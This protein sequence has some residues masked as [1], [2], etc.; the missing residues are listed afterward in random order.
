LTKGFQNENQGSAS[1]GEQHKTTA[2]PQHPESVAAYAKWTAATVK[3]FSGRKI[4]WEIWNEPNI[5][6][7]QPKP[8]AQQY[9]ALAL[10]SC[11]AIRE[12][13]PHATIVGPA[14]SGFPW[15]FL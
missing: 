9:A 5:H 8:D 3:H 15:E 2:S 10:T 11:Q 4:I 7:W 12:A 6:F 14:T 1:N 13:D